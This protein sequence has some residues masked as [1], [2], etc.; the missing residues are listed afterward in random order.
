MST[1]DRRSAVSH[2]LDMCL[3]ATDQADRLITPHRFRVS[4][5]VGAHAP[6]VPVLRGYDD[7]LAWLTTELPNL[8]A[9]CRT[10]AELAL[11]TKCWQLAYALRGFFFLTKRWD[12]WIATHTVA[13]ESARRCGDRRGEAVTLNNLGLAFLERGDLDAADAHYRG[14]LALFQDLQDEHGVS[15]ARANRAGVLYYRGDHAAA[16]RENRRAL[17]F[18]ERSGSRRNAGI[19]LRSIGLVE[20]E[21]GRFQAATRHLRQALDVFG[22]LG[23]QLDA[24]MA[25]NGLGEGY[26]WLGD[27]DGARQCHL[28]AIE[29]S[30]RCGSVYEEAR[31]HDRLGGIAA[32]EAKDQTARYHWG[33]ALSRYAAL[34][35]PRAE[36]IRILLTDLDPEP[37]AEHGQDQ[38]P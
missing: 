10:A 27:L 12:A 3:R 17:A 21:L 38:P 5:D 4:L 34:G 19:T 28:R 14:S 33:Q 37:G 36:D 6:D 29:L 20:I 16:L 35:A 32:D 18:Y 8:V 22:D 9:L 13:L 26:H 30:Q 11:D 7:A 2:L 15:N 25:N 1:E 23:L 31:A 24:A